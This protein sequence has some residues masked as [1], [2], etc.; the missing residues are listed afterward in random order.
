MSYEEK[1]IELYTK[2]F[3]KDDKLPFSDKI[4]LNKQRTLCY[5]YNKSLRAKNKEESIYWDN[6][7][8]QV[9]KIKNTL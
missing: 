4:K 9:L 6:I 8:E 7:K 2:I 5:C 3:L 1:A